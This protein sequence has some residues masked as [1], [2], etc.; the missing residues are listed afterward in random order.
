MEQSHIFS[1]D[2]LDLCED[3]FNRSLHMAMILNGGRM[4][5]NDE[6]FLFRSIRIA[7]RL[8][9]LDARSETV[10]ASL[11]YEVCDPN[12]MDYKEM[13][14]VVREIKTNLGIEVG[15]MSFWLSKVQ[16]DSSSLKD[17][18]KDFEMIAEEMPE[19]LLILICNQLEE[20]KLLKL[21]KKNVGIAQ[22]K[23]WKN[24]YLP[25]YSKYVDEMPQL[26]ILFKELNKKV[27]S[28]RTVVLK[29]K[30]KN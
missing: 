26:K 14:Y 1:H 17:Q 7:Q 5:I 8:I 27:G 2:F 30:A 22:L 9:D 4:R 28:L 15:A 11:L 3:G 6:P 21:Q 20:F 29:K 18:A 10:Q 16:F 25:L 12:E 24:H 19:I 13:E 23:A